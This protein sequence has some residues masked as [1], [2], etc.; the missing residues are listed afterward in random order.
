[1]KANN[2]SYHDTRLPEE[3]ALSRVNIRWTKDELALAIMGFRKF[4]QNFKVKKQLLPQRTMRVEVEK[5]F[6]TKRLR[7]DFN[8]SLSYMC[9]HLGYC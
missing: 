7:N 5:N 6:F 8:I 2:E 1:M 4:G 3:A 9:V